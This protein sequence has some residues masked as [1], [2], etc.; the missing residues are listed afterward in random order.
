MLC[1]LLNEYFQGDVILIQF[2][3]EGSVLVSV[4]VMDPYSEEE[5]N[6]PDGESVF[7]V[8]PARKAP[9]SIQ[10]S[11][12]LP[13]PSSHYPK[14]G[15]RREASDL[16][17]GNTAPRLSMHPDDEGNSLEA[18]LAWRAWKLTT[19]SGRTCKPPKDFTV[20][21]SVEDTGDQLVTNCK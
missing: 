18:V 4:R 1:L 21:V 16:A 15:L 2:T 7:I 17:R 10:L 13:N 8:D 12:V 19:I 9:A 5:E 14:T 20:I 11:Q 6:F 3:K